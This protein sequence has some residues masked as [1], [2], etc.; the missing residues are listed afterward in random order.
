MMVQSGFSVAF[1]TPFAIGH[2]GFQGR[3]NALKEIVAL[4]SKLVPVWH[5]KPIC[6]RIAGGHLERKTIKNMLF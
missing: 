6:L 1:A 4:A 2:P 3:S 5:Y